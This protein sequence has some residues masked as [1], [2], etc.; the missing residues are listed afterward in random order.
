V[1]AIIDDTDIK[2]AF[3]AGIHRLGYLPQP[4]AFKSQGGKT[5]ST[6]AAHG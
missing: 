3:E 1:E 2:F 4:T 6:F 5:P